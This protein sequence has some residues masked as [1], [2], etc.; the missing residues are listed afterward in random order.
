[1]AEIAFL[2]QD[3]I[4]YF[5]FDEL[6]DGV[7][8]EYNEKPYLVYGSKIFEWTLSGY[9]APTKPTLNINIKL[10]TPFRY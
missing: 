1:M 6:Q 4:R 7:F 5:R 2:E 3:E 8:V 10:L 9:I